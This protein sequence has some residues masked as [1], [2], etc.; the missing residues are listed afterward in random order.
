MPSEASESSETQ[1]H[2]I[3][4]ELMT[5][6]PA[7]A[8]EFYRALFGWTILETHAGPEGVYRMVQHAG[9]EL[10][11]IVATRPEHDHPRPHW[12]SYARVPEVE[13]ICARA[14]KLGGAELIGP[15]ELPGVGRLA[16]LADPTGAHWAVFAVSRARPL[17]ERPPPGVFCWTQLLTPE[18][19]RA[20]AFYGELLR[21][22]V[23]PAPSPDGLPSV[24][25][26]ASGKLHAGA[27]Q[28]PPSATATASWLPYVA[29][30]E[31]TAAER[32]AQSLGAAILRGATELPGLG[33]FCVL[34]DPTGA[35]LALW[36]DRVPS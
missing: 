32:R 2:F 3:W 5:E 25:F 7:R 33:A 14:R 30:A 36:E 15:T 35:E 9:R 6:D 24:M 20:R 13:P 16:V 29:V 31:I 22:G 17:P 27:L 11:G 34:Q 12:L 23:E 10:G 19:A 4:R 1:G 21:W 26:R 8:A 28:L 18:V